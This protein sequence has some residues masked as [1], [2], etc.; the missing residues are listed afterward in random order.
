MR[1]HVPAPTTWILISLALVLPACGAETDNAGASGPTPARTTASFD[2]SRYEL[3]ADPGDA[4]STTAAR[5]LEGDDEVVVEGRVHVINNNGY[6]LFKL[7][8]VALKYCGQDEG[9][10]CGCPTPWDY[11]CEDVDKCK[12]GDL[13]V[14]VRGTDGRPMAA[15]P[16]QTGLRLLDLIAVK[17]R[18]ETSADGGKILVVTEGWYRR[19]RPTLKDGLEWPY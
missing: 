8:D 16:E 9:E 6:A 13:P 5:Q 2:R 18:L 3:P 4:L 14:E 1:F 19:E 11:C 10:D 12:A 7:Q 17:G 15:T